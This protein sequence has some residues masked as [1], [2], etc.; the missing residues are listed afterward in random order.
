MCAFPALYTF[1]NDKL[2]TN[3]VPLKMAAIKFGLVTNYKYSFV[4]F[5]VDGTISIETALVHTV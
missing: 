3:N 5:L 4:T 2:G 1:D